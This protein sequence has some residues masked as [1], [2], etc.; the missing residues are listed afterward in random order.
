MTF[1][2]YASLPIFCCSGGYWVVEAQPRQWMIRKPDVSAG[3]EQLKAEIL[4]AEIGG[5]AKEFVV[6]RLLVSVPK[7]HVVEF[8]ITG[9]ARNTCTWGEFAF[10]L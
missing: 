9:E 6:S 1:Q 8:H 5:P 2:M 3:R 10:Y 4:V 7:A